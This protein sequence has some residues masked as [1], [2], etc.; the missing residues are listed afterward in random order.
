MT[1]EGRGDVPVTLVVTEVS[2]AFGC[3]VVG[4][5]AVTIGTKV[6]FGAEKIHYSSSATLGFALWGNACLAGRRVDD[7]VSDFVTSLGS[8]ATPRSAGRDLAALLTQEGM[9]DGRDWLALRGGVHVCGYENSV[10]VLF[11][12]HT[13][14][15]PPDPQ[16]PFQ[17]YEDFPD[18]SAGCH[19]R[20]GYYRMFSGL[21]DGMQHYAAQ[22]RV[23]GYKWPNEGVEDRVSYFTILV[24]TVARTLEAAGR[25][26]AVG[27][28]VSSFAFNRSGIQVDKRVPR[29]TTDF[30]VSGAAN[31]SFCELPSNFSCTGRAEARR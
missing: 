31:A 4:D 25:V 20:N 30:C 2:E 19:L 14:H 28:T 13:G 3:V 16:G 21:F 5:S 7:L 24:N 6:I 26:A 15:E 9:R 8:V 11:H 29:G 23:L 27:G 18:A 17:L 12:V 22:L 1:L 10:P